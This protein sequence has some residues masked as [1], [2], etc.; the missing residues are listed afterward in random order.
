MKKPLKGGITGFK[1][2]TRKI[3]FLFMFFVLSINLFPQIPVNG[4]CK[5]QYYKIAP[6]F[7]NFFPLNYNNDS[8]TDLLLFNPSNKKICS[9][10]GFQNG[11]FGKEHI[12]EM[13]REIS[14]I[15]LLW[16]D[17]MKISGYAFISRKQNS[18][19]IMKI[20]PEGLPEI[21]SE[22]KFNTYP[23]NLST[24]DI[25]NDGSPELL[26]SGST[27]NGLSI[28]YQNKKLQEK[29]IAQN[30]SYPEAVFV[31]LNNDNYPDI[32]AFDLFS[33]RIQFF[34]NNSRGDFKKVREIPLNNPVYQLQ[35]TDMDIDSYSDLIFSDQ[36]GISI[37]YGD[38]SSSYND[39]INISTKYKVDKFI[40]GDFNSDGKIDIAYLND[41]E[42]I[43]SLIFAKENRKFYPELIYF[44]KD[45]LTDIIPYYSKFVN[46]IASLSSNGNLYL[47]SNLTSFSDSVSIVSGAYPAAVSYFDKDNNGIHDLCFIDNFNKTLNLLIRSNSGIPET[48]FPIPLFENESSVIVN[49]KNPQLKTFYCYT[50]NNKLIEVISVDLKKN[51]YSR[52]SLYITGALKDIKFKIGNDK[53]YAAFIRDRNL[54]V[55]IFSE[56]EG[57]YS[58][59]TIKDIQ[60]NTL[61]AA[62]SV[63]GN[64]EVFYASSGND[65][66]NIGERS[67]QENKKYSD[68][69]TE[70]KNPDNVLLFAGNFLNKSS[71]ALYGFLK[72][73]TNNNLMFFT[74]PRTFITS[75]RTN[76]LPFRI[77]DKNQLFF[78][79]LSFNS[80]GRVCLYDD[81]TQT[82][83]SINLSD[84]GKNINENT[85]A[86]HI[87]AGSFFI[88]NMNSRQ[89]HIVYVNNF[90]NCISIKE[91][92]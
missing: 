27:F 81:S 22:I 26:I 5:Y 21:E 9:L 30:T 50:A 83:N 20:N 47:V 57:R 48:W 82:I 54:F 59:F 68:F 38:F 78:G 40:T 33:G 58:D 42:G 84:D 88:K 23:D 45:S 56:D 77:K 12:Y 46:G 63:N 7:K 31:D 44:K 8:Y 51:K 16:T 35:S 36:R 74:E 39:T 32:A 1:T 11:T 90:E 10:D 55:S 29:K 18:A 73:G 24:A 43:L 52:N 61:D 2:G 65:A 60:N 19:G 3:N 62:L 86:D 66:I 4:F 72:S 14:G 6:G 17:S 64:P 49:N 41:E 80:P 76:K 85:L 91:L 92:K 53:L 69:L 15:Q 28:L 25:D 67:L 89:Y 13:R 87:S 37:S 34:Y 79:E 71:S 75:D 70:F